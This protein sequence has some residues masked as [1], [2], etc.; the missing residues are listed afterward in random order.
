MLCRAIS[1]QATYVHYKKFSHLLDRYQELL[2]TQ[3]EQWF[4]NNKESNNEKFV[5]SARHICISN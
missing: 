3:F 1:H 5:Y 2:F 4:P